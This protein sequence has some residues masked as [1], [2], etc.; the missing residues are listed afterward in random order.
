MGSATAWIWPQGC[1]LDG[2][3]HA[4][5]QAASRDGAVRSARNLRRSV[6]VVV[7]MTATGTQTRGPVG[8]G[9][10]GHR[11]LGVLA[12]G[13]LFLS[14]VTVLAVQDVLGA[15][16][17]DSPNQGRFDP[18]SGGGAPPAHKPPNKGR[19]GKPN[20][21]VVMVDDMRP[22]DL[23]FMPFTSRFFRHQGIEFRNSFSPNPLCCP[24]RA[25]FLTGMYSHNHEVL[26]HVYPWGFGAFDD[27]HTLSGALQ[28]AGYR[29]GFVGKYLNRYG[30]HNSKVTGQPSWHYVPDGWT[31]W[32]ATVELPPGGGTGVGGGTYHFFDTIFNVNG[33]TR[34][35]RTGRYQSN[36]IEGYAEHLVDKYAGRRHPFFLYVNFVAPHYGWP[37]ESD[38][39]AVDHRRADGSYEELRT[40]AR[41]EW[42]KDRFDSVLTHAPGIPVD[43]GPSEVDVTDKPRLMQLPGLT[44]ADRDA[45]LEVSRQR[46]E[47]LYVVDRQVRSLVRRL[48]VQGELSDTVLMFTS[49]NGYFLGEHRVL[50]GK[51]LPHEPSIRVPLLMA[52]GGLPE[53]GTRFDPARTIDLPVTIADLAGARLPGAPDGASLVPVILGGDRGWAVPTVLESV[54]EDSTY[55]WAPGRAKR[56]FTDARTSIGLRTARYKYVVY[57]TGEVE[58]YDLLLDPNELENVAADPTYVRVGAGLH[59]LWLAY[60]DCSGDQC[61]EPMPA[62]WRV[63]PAELAQLTNQ[64]SRLVELMFGY[65]R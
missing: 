50:S 46:A 13:A 52:G 27:S 30:R 34:Q 4:A 39:P 5:D 6:C 47:S 40:V 36:V 21:I 49:D 63:G 14:G 32:Y 60:K 57:S 11:L 15:P 59:R 51:T 33:H 48:R 20:V 23:R 7:G 17:R 22:D 64:Q 16:A 45:I 42:V 65:R 26:S 56:G 54:V 3:R 9:T 28:R 1:Q 41:P 31:D 19:S 24:A 18:P 55:A 38:D 25:S 61:R 62:K 29:T 8:R 37:E 10:A 35:D 12:C 2:G 43:G 53:G 44:A 58:L